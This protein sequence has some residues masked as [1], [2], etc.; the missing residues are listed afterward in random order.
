MN[1]RRWLAGVFRRDTRG[2]IPPRDD[3]DDGIGVL[4]PAGPRPLRGGAHA[5]P[6]VPEKERQDRPRR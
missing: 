6:P 4:V 1:L 2:P 5:K 3:Q